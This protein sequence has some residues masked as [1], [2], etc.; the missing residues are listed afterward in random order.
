M[1]K[2]ILLTLMPLCCLLTAVSAKTDN[3]IIYKT[4]PFD[5]D[6]RD[7]IIIENESS[8]HILEATVSLV[9][10]KKLVRLG[11]VRNVEP[12]DDEEVKEYDD[13]NLKN[14]RGRKLAIKIK[15]AR[16]RSGAGVTYK[17]RV[18]LYERRHDLYIKVERGPAHEQRQET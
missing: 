11:T 10:N 12:D 3:T 18:T 2:E 7:K 16:S 4:V 5:L 14:L 17:F 6:I 1:K 15:G 8:Y 13:D 9:Q